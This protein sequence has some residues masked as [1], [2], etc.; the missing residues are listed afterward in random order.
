M[1]GCVEDT[2]GCGE[3]GIPV[4]QVCKSTSSYPVPGS[5]P[6]RTLAKDIAWETAQPCQ[7][8]SDTQRLRQS[9]PQK[10]LIAY[11]PLVPCCLLVVVVVVMYVCVTYIHTCTRVHSAHVEIRIGNKQLF[12]VSSV[13]PSCVPE[14]KLSSQVSMESLC[15]ASASLFQWREA[16]LLGRAKSEL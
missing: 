8:S 11:V 2:T 14:T 13:L 9:D 4:H 15:Q 12:G 1:H 3:N 7:G 6:L 5:R 16:C 10:D